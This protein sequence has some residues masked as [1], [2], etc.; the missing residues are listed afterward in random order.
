MERH[1]LITQDANEKQVAI[2]E[3]GKLEEFYIERPDAK[4]LFGNIYAG[5]V[6]TVIPGIDAAFV[7]IGTGRTV[8]SMSGMR[9]VRRSI[10]IPSMTRM[11]RKSPKVSQRWKAPKASP[12]NN[13]RRASTAIAGT[14]TVITDPAVG[15]SRRS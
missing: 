13:R 7:D 9:S 2:L 10:S 8:F 5:I 15:V 12:S 11:A 4:K 6:K 1:I 3:D 14:G